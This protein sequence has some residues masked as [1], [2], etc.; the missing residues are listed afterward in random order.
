VRSRPESPDIKPQPQPLSTS[1]LPMAVWED[2]LLPLLEC[3]DAARLGSTCKALKGV[4]REVFRNLSSV[5]W[6]KLQA[7]LT[8]FPRARTIAL[9]YHQPKGWE[10]HH[11]PKG[12]E[13]AESKALVEWLVGGG[14]GGAITRIMTTWR[15]PRDDVLNNFVHAA[16][17]RGALPSLKAVAA[18]MC[19]APHRAMLAEGRLGGMHELCLT[20]VWNR[21]VAPQLAALG[22]LR[23]LPALAKL[24]LR[25]YTEGGYRPG[26]VQW[27]P[28]IPP[29]LKAL[30][31]WNRDCSFGTSLLLALPGMLAASGAGIERLKLDMGLEY[32]FAWRVDERLVHVAQALRCCSR[33][34]KTFS[35]D[36]RL[37]V[38]VEYKADCADAWERLRVQWADV[39]SSMSTCRELEVLELPSI[40][41]EPLFPPGTAFARLTHLQICDSRREDPPDAGVMGLWELMA[42]GGLPALATLKVMLEEDQWGGAEEVRTRVAPAFEAVAG[43]LRHFYL[44]HTGLDL[45]DYPPSGEGMGYEWGVAVG[46]LRRLND[47]ALG[48]WHDG[49]IHHAFAQGLAAGRGDRPLPLLWR[50]GAAAGVFRNPDLVAS[51]L[52]PSVRV[53]ASGQHT[54]QTVLLTACAL[55]QAGYEH[56]WAQLSFVPKIWTYLFDAKV[57]LLPQCA[58]AENRAI[59]DYHWRQLPQFFD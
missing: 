33:T 53:F 41:V 48:L 37:W 8:T 34:L 25:L 26:P 54:Q 14:H 20:V 5:R 27:A 38:G 32:Q 4:V 22:L 15:Y 17:R 3:K 52:L 57:V 21:E 7:A 13:D 46:K 49:R 2:H 29:S 44:D 45:D 19:H 23:Q 59:Y 58:I 47:L 35:L 40:G 55:R 16:L 10:A 9:S 36:K 39:L 18:N 24:E 51:L 1:A 31:I 30:Y 28:F 42:S 6:E 12:W 50:M 56:I 43:T 11:Q